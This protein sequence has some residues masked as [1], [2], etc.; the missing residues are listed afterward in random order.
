M[1][2]CA[3]RSMCSVY[4]AKPNTASIPPIKMPV[5]YSIPTDAAALPDE[6]ACEALAE[7]EVSPLELPDPPDPPEPPE[8]DGEEEA[9]AE[10]LLPPDD[11]V[12]ELAPAV[13]FFVPHCTLWQAVWPVRSLG[14][15]AVQSPRQRSQM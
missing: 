14:W 15:A 4:S 8:A 2:K 5:P 11:A 10:A 9:V 7:A 12:V 3:T 13:A 6:L 1:L